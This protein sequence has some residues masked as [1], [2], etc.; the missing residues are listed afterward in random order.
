MKIRTNAEPKG[1]QIFDAERPRLVVD[2]IY[3]MLLLSYTEIFFLH[4]KFLKG[5]F[6]I[7]IF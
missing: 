1:M 7:S 3:W 2:K 5:H 4:E 6:K